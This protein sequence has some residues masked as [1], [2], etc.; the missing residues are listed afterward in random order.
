MTAAELC[1]DVVVQAAADVVPTIFAKGRCEGD[2]CLH[3]AEC[4]TCGTVIFQVVV[5]PLRALI[6]FRC[7]ACGHRSALSLPAPSTAS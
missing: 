6:V 4:T 2:D 7:A 5:V 3:P 1:A